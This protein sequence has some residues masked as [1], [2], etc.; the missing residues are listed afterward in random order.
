VASPDEMAKA[1]PPPLYVAP[2]A[3][4]EKFPELSDEIYDQELIV[5]K[6]NG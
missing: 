2:T 1:I 4:E 5:A 3:G 6:G